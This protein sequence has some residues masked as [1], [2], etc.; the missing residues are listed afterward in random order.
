MPSFAPAWGSLQ[1]K[2]AIYDERSKKLCSVTYTFEAEDDQG[3]SDLYVN[4]F[5]LEADPQFSWT[6]LKPTASDDPNRR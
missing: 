5:Y 1:T 4:G 6:L 3:A 2:E